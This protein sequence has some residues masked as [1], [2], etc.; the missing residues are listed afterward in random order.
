MSHQ[1]LFQRAAGHATRYREMLG[2]RSPW[3]PTS[4]FAWI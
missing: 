3:P 4:P 1:A 2:G